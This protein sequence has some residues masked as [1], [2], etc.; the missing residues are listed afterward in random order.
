MNILVVSKFY[1]PVI[2]GVEST[3]KELCEHFVRK[4]HRCT[5]VVMS[6]DQVGSESIEGVEV[7]RFPV[8]SRLLGG[9]NRPIWHYLNKVLDRGQYDVVYLH[10]FHIV[11]SLEAAVFCKLHS[12]PYV[13]SPHYHGKGHTVMRDL[14]F[15]GYRSVGRFGLKGARTVITGSWNERALLLKD[16]PG[17]ADKCVVIPPGIKDRPKLDLPRREGTVLYV[18]RL[19]QYK[20]LDR[21]LEAM[22][23]MQEQGLR[24]RLRV[25]GTGPERANLEAQA[26]RLGLGEQVT[27][28]GELSED[29]VTEEY[30]SATCLVLLSSA[31]AYGLVVA[32]ALLAGT[33]CVVA[34]KEALHEFLSEPGVLGV[35]YPPDPKEVARLLTR[36][37]TEPMAVKVGPFS[38]RITSW[39]N[40]ADRYIEVLGQAAKEG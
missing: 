17:I 13:F 28:L 4:G 24:A 40:I 5:A 15:R 6:K 30:C 19:M 29:Q 32:E 3:V 37:L 7:V 38:P 16:F 10:N 2:G 33:P 18:G 23:V 27:F 21:V 25:V 39:S 34:D 12:L 36:V 22:K 26:S 14:A 35:P 1:Y 31:E 11:L 20:G 8:D 9:F